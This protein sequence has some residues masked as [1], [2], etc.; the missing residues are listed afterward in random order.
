MFGIGMPELLLILCIA[1]M[2]IGPKKLPDLARSLGRAMREFKKAT[3]ELKES[4][5]A[6]ADF[7]EVRDS[8]DGIKGD[9]KS[10]FDAKMDEF[11]KEDEPE[12]GSDAPKK[13]DPEKPSADSKPSVDNS[14]TDDSETIDPKE[15]ANGPDGESAKTA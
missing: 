14:E 13:D 15:P 2:V 11:M 7:K 5:N 9:L 1:L 3:S 12:D 4:I 8:F 10:S 6:E